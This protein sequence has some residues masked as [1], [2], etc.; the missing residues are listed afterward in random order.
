MI[1]H[2]FTNM[3]LKQ[4]NL[5]ITAMQ[6]V[7][8]PHRMKDTQPRIHPETQWLHSSNLYRGIRALIALC[9]PPSR[10][11][12]SNLDV[13]KP[14]SL[15]PAS[16]GNIIAL[17]LYQEGAVGVNFTQRQPIKSDIKTHF[18]CIFNQKIYSLGRGK[19]EMTNAL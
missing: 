16:S 18:Q 13:S 7:M 1:K 6:G 12:L 19:K 10:C 17:S 2:N 8:T 3:K 11:S 14:P 15:P 5:K 4:I 9:A